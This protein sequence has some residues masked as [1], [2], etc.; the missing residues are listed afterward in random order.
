MEKNPGKRLFFYRPCFDYL[1]KSDMISKLKFYL[2]FIQNIAIDGLFM[3]LFTSSEH[4]IERELHLDW[5]NY[6]FPKIIASYS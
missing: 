5:F 6:R 3:R 4:L 2:S 1:E